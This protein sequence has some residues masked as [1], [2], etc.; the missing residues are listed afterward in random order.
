MLAFAAIDTTD[1]L[2]RVAAPRWRPWL[3]YVAAG[4]VLLAGLAFTFQR[5]KPLDELRREPSA[6]AAS[7][8]DSCLRTIPADASV[9]ATSALVPHISDRRSIY[10]LDDRPL[11]GTPWLALDTQ[12]WIF[13]LTLGDIGRIVDRSLAHGYGVRCSNARTVVLARGVATRNLNP[14]LRA[15]LRRSERQATP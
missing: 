8:I 6:L 2:R 10:Q 5:I 4:A 3:A 9:S 11:P 14:A 15:L 7:S 13:P 12:T 1:R